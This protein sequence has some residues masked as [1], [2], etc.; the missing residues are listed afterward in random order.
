M[1]RFTHAEMLQRNA[2]RSDTNCFWHSPKNVSLLASAWADFP[3]CRWPMRRM[4]MSHISISCLVED[5][6]FT[7]RKTFRLR[8]S[9]VRAQVRSCLS[10]SAT[11]LASSSQVFLAISSSVWVSFPCRS[12][13]SALAASSALET[14]S[15]S[16]LSSSDSGD[17]VPP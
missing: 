17:V 3:M 8:N 15:G 13:F 11:S 1:R 4:I 16:S 6:N 14:S 5:T 2:L 12:A 9:K 10:S 7:T